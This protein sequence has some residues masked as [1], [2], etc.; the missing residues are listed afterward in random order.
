MAR[1]TYSKVAIE[2]DKYNSWNSIVPT[3]D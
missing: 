3:C 1:H 2:H